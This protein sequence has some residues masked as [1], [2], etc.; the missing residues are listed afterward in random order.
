MQP[1]YVTLLTHRWRLV[2]RPTSRPPP[3]SERC[4][5]SNTPAQRTPA[6]RCC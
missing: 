6:I 1:I 4:R 2:D 5:P 3:V